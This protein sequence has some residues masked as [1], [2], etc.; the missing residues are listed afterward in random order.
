MNCQS[1]KSFTDQ[2]LNCYAVVTGPWTNVP[3]QVDFGDDNTETFLP[4]GITFILTKN[5]F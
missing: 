2:Y 3:L 1:E 4:Q 5:S